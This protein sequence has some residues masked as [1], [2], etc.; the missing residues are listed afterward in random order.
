MSLL[1]SHLRLCISRLLSCWTAVLSAPQSCSRGGWRYGAA[2]GGLWPESRCDTSAGGLWSG[3]DRRRHPERSAP[4]GRRGG[5]VIREAAG[6][7]LEGA[8]GLTSPGPAP[9]R[10][11]RSAPTG[12]RAPGQM[13][14]RRRLWE[15]DRLDLPR[16]QVQTQSFGL[17][18][19]IVHVIACLVSEASWIAKGLA[20]SQGL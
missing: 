16:G 6:P 11:Q 4:P 7:R 14:G 12:Q 18:V 15:P 1:E 2:R 10:R 19:S 13:T 3:T 5:G 20:L 8:A 17:S 9:L